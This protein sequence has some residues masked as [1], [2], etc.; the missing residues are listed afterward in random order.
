MKQHKGYTLLVE[1]NHIGNH[2]GTTSTTLNIVNYLRVGI[3][4]EIWL[5]LDMHLEFYIR[6]WV[7]R[8]ENISGG[9]NI[10]CTRNKI[11]DSWKL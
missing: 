10:S 9:K 5:N 1:A 2:D 4:I 8:W 3:R 11:Q 7:W 6:S